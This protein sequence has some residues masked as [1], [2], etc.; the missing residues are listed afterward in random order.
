MKSCFI[1]NPVLF[2][3]PLNMK[4][5]KDHNVWDFTNNYSVLNKSCPLAVSFCQL[6]YLT[7]VNKYNYFKVLS[8]KY[9]KESHKFEK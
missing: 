1:I 8:I 9:Y 4:L 2:F 6:Q 5:T 3:L 7:C